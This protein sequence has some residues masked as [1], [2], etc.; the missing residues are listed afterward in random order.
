LGR[1][2]QRWF[3]I[4][5]TDVAAFGFKFFLVPFGDGMGVLDSKRLFLNF[6]LF[7]QFKEILVASKLQHFDLVGIED[8][9]VQ[10]L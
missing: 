3:L 4:K 6:I 5:E 7:E 8:F 10:M 1:L 2:L 9:V